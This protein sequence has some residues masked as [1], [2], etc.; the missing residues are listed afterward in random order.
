MKIMENKRF[1]RN[2]KFKLVCVFTQSFQ[3]KKETKN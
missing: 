2:S 1:S 3:E